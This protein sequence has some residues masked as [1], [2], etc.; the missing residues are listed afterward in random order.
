M[1]LVY[2]YS[3]DVVAEVETEEEAKDLAEAVFGR[4]EEA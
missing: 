3:E 2:D 4:Y 1:Y